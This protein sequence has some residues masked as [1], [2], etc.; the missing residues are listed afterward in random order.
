MCALERVV[1]RYVYP[2]F[3][4]VANP[5]ILGLFNCFLLEFC[6]QPF[7]AK[8]L[9]MVA[10]SLSLLA[11]SLPDE[12]LLHALCRLHSWS[13][14]TGCNPSPSIKSCPRLLPLPSLFSA[15]LFALLYY[16]GKGRKV[17]HRLKNWLQQGRY[18]LQNLVTLYRLGCV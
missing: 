3:L 8:I 9:T 18:V 12:H 16:F 11:S 4:L 15:V 5:L 14:L 6:S 1:T 17:V 10:V 13:R 2:G 7:V